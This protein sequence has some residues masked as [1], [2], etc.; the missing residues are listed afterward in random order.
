MEKYI[1]GIFIFF[2]LIACQ[3]IDEKFS[4][5]DLSIN[6][7]AEFFDSIHRAPIAE[8]DKSLEFYL[9]LSEKHTLAVDEIPILKNYLFSV[10][11]PEQELQR[12]QVYPLRD[13]ESSLYLLEFSCYK[14]YCSYL[15]VDVANDNKS[16][17]INDFVQFSTHSFTPDEE[18]IV[19]QFFSKDPSTA[20][21]DFVVFDREKWKV[22]P[23]QVLKDECSM[24]QKKC[25]IHSLEWLGPQ[26]ISIEMI[27]QQSPS[28]NN[29]ARH[30]YEEIRTEIILQIE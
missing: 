5:K 21:T 27:P 15:I 16:F 4:T 7:E 10:L 3:P 11:N 17:L 23:Y 19:F 20:T 18:K 8:S 1:Y 29:E 26:T 25:K 30:Y 28:S 12:I 9:S 22:I 24:D 6:S 13:D 14:H 2:L